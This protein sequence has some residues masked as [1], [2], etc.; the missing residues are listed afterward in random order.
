MHN[1]AAPLVS[2]W[3]VGAVVLQQPPPVQATRPS[4]LGRGVTIDWLRR[5]VLVDGTIVRRDVPLEFIACF[6]GK[7]HESIIRMDA[8][9]QH[10][11]DALG[12]IGL[13]SGQPHA[14]DDQRQTY[15]PPTGD[16]V[17]VQIE[18]GDPPQRIPA[19]TWVRDVEYDRPA[20]PL[21]WRFG[22]SRRSAGGLLVADQTGA[23]VAIVDHPEALLG[24]PR[25]RSD[26]NAALWARAD[27]TRVPEIGSRVRIVLTPA[28]AGR[29]PAPGLRIDEL[30][31]LLIDDRTAHAED[32]LALLRRRRDLE[33]D[34]K[35]VIRLD[36]T[37]R[38]DER[39][40]RQV[41]AASGL[42]DAVEWRP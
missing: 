23:G 39:L 8:S 25:P 31:R 17:D 5:E 7:E 35:L 28:S 42:H 16:W 9:A 38:A 29:T 12:L 26:S 21:G 30:G 34:A 22:G 24:M 6:A 13:T 18:V 2:A 19:E 1:V 27:A 3:L 14:W 36:S 20:L 33:P 10:V 41:V 32:L 15:A 11:R 4:Q 40:W 37:L